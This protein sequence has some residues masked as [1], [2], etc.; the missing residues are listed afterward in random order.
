MV[1][2]WTQIFKG[3][4]Q[5]K[6]TKM[7]LVFSCVSPSGIQ[8]RQVS[9]VSP[10]GH[11]ALCPARW[12]RPLWLPAAAGRHWQRTRAGRWPVYSLR[13][14]PLQP[15]GGSPPAD[16]RGPWRAALSMNHLVQVPVS[17]LSSAL[18]DRGQIPAVGRPHCP[19]L[20][21]LNPTLT[22]VNSLFIRFPQLLNLS[23]PGILWLMLGSWLHNKQC[24]I[25]AFF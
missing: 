22:F 12:Q 21:F 13:P 16:G 17:A 9:C 14:I 11:P 19:F 1:T 2:E 15:M 7:A 18:S 25:Y 10:P 5:Q 3:T 6:T 4:E 20:G 24:N 23:V 8:G